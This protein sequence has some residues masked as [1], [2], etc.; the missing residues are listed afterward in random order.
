[1]LDILSNLRDGRCSRC[2]RCGVPR[3]ALP[4]TWLK[5]S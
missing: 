4:S 1:V 2:K 5:E 3:E